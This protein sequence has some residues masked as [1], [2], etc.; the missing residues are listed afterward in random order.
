MVIKDGFCVPESTSFF[1]FRDTGECTGL[2][3][4]YSSL[5]LIV[6]GFFVIKKWRNR[7][8]KLDSERVLN[9]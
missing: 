6:I 5:S 3:Y 9:Y 7:K 8:W 1:N 4:N 2:L